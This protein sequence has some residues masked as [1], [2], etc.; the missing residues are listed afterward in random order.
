MHQNEEHSNISQH[1]LRQYNTRHLSESSEADGLH[2]YVSSQHN[3]TK[4][5]KIKQRKTIKKRIITY[6]YKPSGQ[7]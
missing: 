3:K 4:Q 6:P 5:N 2:G 7:A 1:R